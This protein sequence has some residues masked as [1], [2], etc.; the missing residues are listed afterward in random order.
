MQ[1][2]QSLESR[3][4]ADK[5]RTSMYEKLPS[6]SSASTCLNRKTS[7]MESDHTNGT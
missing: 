2:V 4:I 7:I 5:D 3:Y 1:G 6:N